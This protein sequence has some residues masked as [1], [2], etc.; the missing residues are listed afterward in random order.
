M[1]ATRRPPSRY[2][3]AASFG[4]MGVNDINKRSANFTKRRLIF[5]RKKGPTKAKLP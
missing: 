3:V 4:M 5:G 2:T 1:L